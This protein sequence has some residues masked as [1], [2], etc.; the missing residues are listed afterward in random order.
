MRLL[1]L[2]SQPSIADLQ[3]VG[4]VPRT[5]LGDLW[6]VG[7]QSEVALHGTPEVCDVCCCTPAI[8][9][10]WRPCYC[11]L[12]APVAYRVENRSSSLLESNSHGRIPSS[13]RHILIVAVIVLQI[14]NTP[15][16]PV[17]GV[18]LLMIQAASSTL[19]SQSAS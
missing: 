7:V 17:L 8:S 13:G 5:R 4:V 16:S 18:N 19:A 11:V 3:H 6:V 9:H 10:V 2:Q 14:V 1:L 12:I 15:I